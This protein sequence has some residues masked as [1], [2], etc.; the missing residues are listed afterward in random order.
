MV[1]LAWAG[2]TLLALLTVFS[3]K[4][5]GRKSARFS[6]GDCVRMNV[7]AAGK[8]LTVLERKFMEQGGWH[9]E[10]TA[11]DQAFELPPPGELRL[12]WWTNETHLIACAAFP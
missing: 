6:V 9:Y 7:D 3:P 4:N 11:V 5:K 10:V 12:T 8:V 1:A 2:A